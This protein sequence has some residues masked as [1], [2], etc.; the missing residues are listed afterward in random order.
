MV[1]HT[2]VSEA[3]R[4]TRVPSWKTLRVIGN[5]LGADE[6]ALKRIWVDCQMQT[7]TPGE[8]EPESLLAVSNSRDERKTHGT[9]S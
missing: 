7:T 9:L 3:L 6:D 1:S 4:G 2:T 5:E 8:G